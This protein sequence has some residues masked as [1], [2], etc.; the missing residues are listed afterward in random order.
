L[1]QA[2]LARAS[3]LEI[4]RTGC[5]S[6]FCRQA[7][8]LA[9]CAC[10]ARGE[11]FRGISYG[12]VPLK[13]QEGASELP[14]DDWMCG[15]AVPMW[16]RAGRADLRNIQLLGANVVRLYGNNAANDHSTFL[17]EAHAEGLGVL[18]GMSDYP[19]YQMMPGNCRE[20]TQYDCFSQVKD[21]YM[22]NL[23]KGFLAMNKTYHAALKVM[24]ILN[25]PDLKMPPD[26][27]TGVADGPIKMSKAIISAFDAML[28]AEQEMGVVEPR[29]NFTT[30]FSY[31]VCRACSRFSN[32]PALGQ[33][34]QLHDA[35][36]HPESYGYKPKHNITAAYFKRWI[37]SFNTA[38][39]A[40]DLEPQFLDHYVLAFPHTPVYIGEYHYVGANQ[41][42]DV[43]LILDIARRT[44]LFKGIS[45]FQYQVAYV[46]TGSEM[47]F[48]MLGLGDYV[49]AEMDYF[50]VTYNIYC[51]AHVDDR[52]TG[53]PMADAIAHVYGGTGLDE[54]TL[55]LPNP[56]G[57]PPRESGFEA[58][59]A[60]NNQRQMAGFVEHVLQ[61]MGASVVGAHGLTAFAQRYASATGRF[62]RMMQE[63]GEGPIWVNF[64][65]SAKCLADRTAGPGVVGEAIGWACQQPG[66][67]DCANI[68]ESCLRST[69]TIGDYVF[70]RYYEALGRARDPLH[71]CSFQGAGIF[72]AS[73]VYSQWTGSPECAAGAD[74]G[75]ELSTT[76]TGT[77][78]A[79]STGTTSST[80]TPPEEHHDLTPA[81][82]PL[83]TPTPS[84]AVVPTPIPT[85]A[86]VP[87]EADVTDGALL[88]SRLR[89]EYILLVLAA[90]L[91]SCFLDF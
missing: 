7:I 30:T 81:P 35:M 8:G 74:A 88:G 73:V 2:V 79:S 18:S 22:H 27:T 69:Y 46:K 53:M 90:G 75:V 43:G 68:P 57:Q 63:L 10:A 52:A 67:P 47:D 31:A 33:I 1:A 24:N 16:G 89:A 55:C 44:P 91:T 38:N 66:S 65:A 4:T 29:L 85:P 42:K 58:V 26:A 54:A 59:A 3:T 15:E 9:L 86:P 70:S 12:P 51:L 39:P 11:L 72:A 87:S 83:P 60:Q 80:T 78:T 77:S 45:F 14:Q 62:T 82:L 19:F 28:E 71:D 6:M 50:S 25:E 5:C 17:D 64:D 37:H 34:A 20:Y 48:G 36:L 40:T 61:H 41:T 13:S 76:S 32:A 49:L 21:S 23:Q 84:P 56:Y